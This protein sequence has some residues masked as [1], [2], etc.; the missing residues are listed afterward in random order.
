M[1]GRTPLTRDQFHSDRAYWLATGDPEYAPA[2]A[3]AIGERIFSAPLPPITPGTDPVER[4][5]A[6]EARDCRRYAE[7]LRGPVTQITSHTLDNAAARLD[8]LADWFER[9]APTRPIDLDAEPRFCGTELM[10]VDADRLMA[11]FQRF[12]DWQA[13]A[14]YDDAAPPVLSTVEIT[15]LHHS[16]GVLTALAEASE[17]STQ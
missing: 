9:P 13:E 1:P 7:Q 15:H 10:K 17:R 6:D 12:S 16:A 3:S 8:L 5:S 4:A 14:H 11:I 2:L